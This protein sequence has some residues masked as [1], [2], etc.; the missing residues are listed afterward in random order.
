MTNSKLRF[1]FR[2]A[3]FVFDSAS[4]SAKAK[5]ISINSEINQ[6][7]TTYYQFMD[8]NPKASVWSQIEESKN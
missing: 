3:K 6:I 5:N 4:K 7:L 1:T 8:S 2:P